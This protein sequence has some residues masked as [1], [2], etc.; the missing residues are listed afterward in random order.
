MNT[1]KLSFTPDTGA[2]SLDIDMSYRLAFNFLRLCILMNKEPIE[3]LD[4]C[5]S[6][7]IKANNSKR[8][9]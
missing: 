1:I 5:M 2:Q 3:I 8:K 6:E 4:I 7:C 9:D